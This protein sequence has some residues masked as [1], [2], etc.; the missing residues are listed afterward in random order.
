M[1]ERTKSKVLNYVVKTLSEQ[2]PFVK[3]TSDIIEIIRSNDVVISNELFSACRLCPK[4]DCK[5]R[6]PRPIAEQTIDPSEIAEYVV[7]IDEHS[8]FAVPN[9]KVNFNLFEHVITQLGRGEYVKLFTE[10]CPYT[11][12]DKKAI[13]RKFRVE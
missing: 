7:R 11:E 3:S 10:R 4:E 9:P 1:D 2:T 8:L 13:V 5:A 6:K 12:E